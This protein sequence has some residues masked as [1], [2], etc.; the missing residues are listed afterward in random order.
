LGN[1]FRVDD[2]IYQKAVDFKNANPKPSGAIPKLILAPEQ[3]PQFSTLS[4]PATD[5]PSEL[6]VLYASNEPIP[7]DC[8]A[9]F[10][11]D[12]NLYKVPPGLKE[13]AFHSHLHDSFTDQPFT[14]A[15]VA[16][17]KANGSARFGL[18]NEWLQTNCSEKPTP[19]LWEL[20][21]ATRRLYTWLQHFYEGISWDQP[22][23]SMV[24]R[25]DDG[26]KRHL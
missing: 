17:I 16:L 20:K 19:Y 18:V 13:D 10:Y 7:L 14:K 4:L 24:I 12:I 23:Y 6:Y 11:H 9:A 2:E 26:A 1:S 15:I 22:H 8:A 21:P 3:D 5:D 25:W